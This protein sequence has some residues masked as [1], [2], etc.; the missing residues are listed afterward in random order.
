MIQ[1]GQRTRCQISQARCFA[2]F[3]FAFLFRHDLNGTAQTAIVTG[4]SPGGIGHECV[5]A[6]WQNGCRVL[7]LSRDESKVTASMSMIEKLDPAPGRKKGSMTYIHFDLLDIPSVIKAAKQ[8]ERTIDRCDILIANAGIMAWP[9]KL[10]NGIEVTF[11][12]HLGHFAFIDTLRPF[13]AR[14]AERAPVQIVVLSSSSQFLL[15][16]RHASGSHVETAHELVSR[17]NFRSVASINERLSSSTA[18]YARSKLANILFSRKLAKDLNSSST[19]KNPVRVTAA[20]PGPTATTLFR[21]T[22]QSFKALPRFEECLNWFLR[23]V[24]LSPK[25]GART[26]LWAATSS[27]ATSSKDR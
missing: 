5:R 13:L 8:V 25:E 2:F 6:L 16:D 21:G 3:F 20:H 11:Y 1:A 14:S 12:N 9:Y 22:A 27:A 26:V 18:R 10:V 23:L 19:T 7:L 4:V 15:T 17:P 24:I